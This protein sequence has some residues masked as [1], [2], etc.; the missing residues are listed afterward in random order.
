MKS[1]LFERGSVILPAILIICQLLFSGCAHDKQEL[2]I[3][4]DAVVT[5]NCE[6]GADI[7]AEYFSLSDSSLHFVKIFMPDGKEYTLPQVVSGSGAR[8]TEGRE[9]EWWIKGDSV[10]IKRHTDEGDWT[11]IFHKCVVEK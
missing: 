10:M 7:R 5:Y 11:A 8:Y 2:H 6:N 3:K 1:K 9:I 4:K